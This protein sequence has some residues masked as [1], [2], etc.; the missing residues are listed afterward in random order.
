MPQSHPI[1]FFRLCRLRY[2]VRKIYTFCVDFASYSTLC[3]KAIQCLPAEYLP[4]LADLFL[5]LAGYLFDYALG[6]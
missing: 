6:F 5:D 3:Q 4:D 1:T 2:C